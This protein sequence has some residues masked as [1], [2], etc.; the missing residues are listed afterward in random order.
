MEKQMNKAL[1]PVCGK[2]VFE[3][4]NVYDI[5][6]VCGWE[7][8]PVQREDLDYEGGAN[9]ESVNQARMRYEKVNHD[10]MTGVK[11]F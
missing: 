6:P 9:P 2:Y 5:C 4:L 7:D 10:W 11:E 3:E 1:C 8:D